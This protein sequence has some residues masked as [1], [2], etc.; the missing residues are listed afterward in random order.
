MPNIVFETVPAADDHW[1]ID[2]DLYNTCRNAIN[3]AITAFNEATTA[4]AK[5]FALQKMQTSLNNI[6]IHTSP[7][8]L[9]NAEGF[10]NVKKTLFPQIKAAYAETGVDTL[11]QARKTD[12]SVA[13]IISDMPTDKADNLMEILHKGSTP[14][15]IAEL[16]SLYPPDDPSQEAE[17]WRQFLE[18]NSIDYL[19]GGNSQ[20]FKVT[21]QNQSIKVLK[22]DNRLGT[23]RSA[24]QHLRETLGDIFT[25]IDADR[26]VRGCDPNGTMISRTLLVTDFCTSGSLDAYSSKIGE[27]MIGLRRKIE[28][29]THTNKMIIQMAQ[30]FT[31][32]QKANCC[33]TDAKW[34]NWLVGSD[35]K[36]R[37]ADTKSFMFTQDGRYSPDLPGNSGPVLKTSGFI[38]NEMIEPET[39][40]D[41]EKVHAYILG[42]NLYKCLGGSG[43]ITDPKSAFIGIFTD[44]PLGLEYQQLIVGLTKENPEDRMSLQD[45][46]VKL[47]ELDIRADPAQKSM[48]EKAKCLGISEP[49][50]YLMINKLIKSEISSGNTN[51]NEIIDK[52]STS[53]D[54][55]G[56]M[57]DKCDSLIQL[58]IN[59]PQVASKADGTLEFKSSLQAIKLEG[60]EKEATR[61]KEKSPLEDQ[62]NPSDTLAKPR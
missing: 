50:F 46:Q 34:D 18:E 52:I 43:L 51:K 21:N 3:E 41:A 29:F 28:K 4:E 39:N 61:L 40:F 54:T 12:S 22:V 44:K 17:Q 7:N 60:M 32:I 56:T 45:A 15:L 48:F 1:G 24:E 30:I 19:G 36:L 55:P 58:E 23:T 25:P 16:T 26:Q 38:P 35:G 11:L 57:F 31:D 49:N 33:F 53:L 62:T 27:G 59:P 9:A 10:H 5:R 2:I 42:C 37:L 20:N 13:R 8:I 47:M 14:S 6:D